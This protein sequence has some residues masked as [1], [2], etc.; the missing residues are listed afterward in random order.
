MGEKDEWVEIPAPVK[1][2]FFSRLPNKFGLMELEF[3]IQACFS[4]AE[5]G[6]K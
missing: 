6:W 2:F 4:S 5:R 1:Y 3:G